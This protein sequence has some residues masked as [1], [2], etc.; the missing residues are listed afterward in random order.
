MPKFFNGTAQPVVIDGYGRFVGG[1]EWVDIDEVTE[2]I[3]DLVKQG[4]LVEVVTPNSDEDVKEESAEGQ[5]TQRRN[6]RSA[7]K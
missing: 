2:R 5:S 1:G 4:Y 6:S 7:K 3:Q